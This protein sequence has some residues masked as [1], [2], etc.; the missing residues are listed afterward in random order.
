MNKMAALLFGMIL[1]AILVSTLC[2]SDDIWR[3]AD[4]GTAQTPIISQ[5]ARAEVTRAP[6]STLPPPDQPPRTVV[7]AVM[8]TATATRTAAPATQASTQTTPPPT[9]DINATALAQ[10]FARVSTVPAPQG[11]HEGTQSVFSVAGAVTLSSALITVI[12]IALN[13]GAGRCARAR[14]DYVMPHRALPPG[15]MYKPPQQRART[16]RCVSSDAPINTLSL[17]S[18]Y[19]S[20]DKYPGSAVK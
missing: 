5:S 2:D 3:P 20:N 16:L 9:I 10:A 12:S 7:K 4:Q 17:P 18:R 11:H 19:L 8:P 14:Q 15:M 13:R 1:L 6:L